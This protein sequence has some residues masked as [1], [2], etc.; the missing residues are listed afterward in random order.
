MEV[1]NTYWMNN[2]LIKI[3]F[4]NYG[5]QCGCSFAL[6]LKLKLKQEQ[7]RGAREEARVPGNGK[8]AATTKFGS[9]LSPQHIAILNC[10]CGMR[11]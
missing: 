9:P 2:D 4:F 10:L 8:G 6:K 7:R 11:S 5:T 1:T 3:G